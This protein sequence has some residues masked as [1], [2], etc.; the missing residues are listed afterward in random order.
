MG[1]KIAMLVNRAALEQNIRPQRGERFF[2]AWSA[3]DD[4]ELRRSQA[5]VDEIIEEAPPGGFAFAAHVL[6]REQHLLAVL[7]HAEGDKK[8]DRCRLLV[9]P[10]AH[11]RA[12]E[13]QPN[14]WL[15]SEGT[16]IPS[17]P[18]A[19]HLAPDPAD[20]IF[21]RGAAKE[22]RQRPA[23][24]AGVGFGKKGPGEKGIGRAGASVKGQAPPAPPF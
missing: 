10:N 1:Q 12:I 11:D 14:D 22:G 13:D 21:A 4:D 24:P 2:K 7:P 18:I 16:A 17:I 3:I 6:D 23:D 5:A 8:R 20:R 15:V 9:E 19:L